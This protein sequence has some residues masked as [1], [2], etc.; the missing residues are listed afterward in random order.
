MKAVVLHKPAPIETKPLHLENVKRRRISDN[1]ILV[2]VIAC[3]VCRTDLHI[4]EGDLKPIRKSIIPGHEIVGKVVQAGSNSSFKKGDIVGVPWLHSTCQS[5][6]YCLSGRENLCE[7]KTFTGYTENGGYAEYVIANSS[8][9]FGLWRGN[10]FEIAPLLCAGIIGYRA[11]KLARPSS[12]TIAMFGFGSSAHLTMQLAQKL[13]YG[14][15]VVSRTPSHLE[16]ARKLGADY[17]YTYD[18]LKHI[19]MKF[20]GAIVFAPSGSV[21]L[22]ALSSVKKGATVAIAD[23]YSTNIPEM[24]Y[25]YIFGEKRLVGVE[26]NARQDA[27]EYLR[28]AHKFGI[29]PK[30][31]VLPLER[32]NEALLM[33]KKGASGSVVLK[34]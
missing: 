22:S 28:L 1:E 15:A 9:S 11:F 20:D 27:I 14:V 19:D 4:A 34:I 33:V 23:I 13:G 25:E 31:T 2:K 3:G 24:P 32:A 6:E 7:R 21:A 12:G 16:L 10:P 5:C 26:A 8:F 30:T 18:K 17:A 29:K